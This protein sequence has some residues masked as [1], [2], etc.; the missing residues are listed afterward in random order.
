MAG[1][2]QATKKIL[3]TP[4]PGARPITAPFGVLVVVVSRKARL[5][6]HLHTGV[7]KVYIPFGRGEWSE[8]PG[9]PHR[10]VGLFS[11]ELPQ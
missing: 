1:F 10:S 6:N 3:R 11:I 5:T 4:S 7:D 8:Q 2:K 9:R